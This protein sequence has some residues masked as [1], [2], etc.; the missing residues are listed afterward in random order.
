M[1]GLC[2]CTVCTRETASKNQCYS[3]WRSKDQGADPQAISCES[4][5]TPPGPNMVLFPGILG[6]VNCWVTTSDSLRS[7]G[8]NDNTSVLVLIVQGARRKNPVT[9][10]CSSGLSNPQVRF[11]T[12][13]RTAS[14]SHYSPQKQ[15]GGKARESN[16][17]RNPNRVG[18][19]YI[20]SLPAYGLMT[21]PA[22]LTA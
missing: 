12:S 3:K 4:T 8:I 18:W 19:L 17:P 5:A 10:T 15:L 2:F 14:H 22:P 1:A 11:H 9:T 20:M 7:T 13:R 16:C 6:R 21:A